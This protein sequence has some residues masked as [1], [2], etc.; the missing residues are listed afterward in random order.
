[1]SSSAVPTTSHRS[2][3]ARAILGDDLCSKL[4]DI[5]VLLVG[6]G[7]IGCELCTFSFPSVIQSKSDLLVPLSYISKKRSVIGVWKHHTARP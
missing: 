5:K 3:N 1:M 4:A 6:A 7:G 2:K